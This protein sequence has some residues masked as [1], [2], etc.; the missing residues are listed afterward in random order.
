MPG[1]EPVQFF[2]SQ[3]QAPLPYALEESSAAMQNVALVQD[4]ETTG[5]PDSV[6]CALQREPL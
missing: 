6:V 3:T 5:T 2:P 1:R 4:T